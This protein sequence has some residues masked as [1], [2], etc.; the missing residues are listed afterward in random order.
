MLTTN[1]D[2][3]AAQADMLALHGISRD[4]WKRY[5]DEGYQHWDIVAPGYK[6][7]MFDIQAA[8]VDAQLDRVDA[9]WE[10]RR[11]LVQRYDEALADLPALEPLQRR[12][13]VK[14]SYH[15]YVVRVAPESGHTRDQ[16]MT[17]LQKQGI[18]VGVHFRAVHLHPYY[19]ETFG[20]EP[21]MCPVA[22]ARRDVVSLP[23]YPSFATTSSNASSRLR[24][25]WRWHDEPRLDLRRCRCSGRSP[26]SWC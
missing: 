24:A 25:R 5:G 15:L 4:A 3:L 7:N 14:A 19:R 16:V 22:E 2:E 12:D 17:A 1:D 26:V 13:Y 8:L 10:R 9:F 18:G 21:G 20:F 11:Q 23:L 6:Y